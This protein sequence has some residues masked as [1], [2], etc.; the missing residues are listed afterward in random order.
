ME[1]AIGGSAQHETVT[2][3]LASATVG[4][5]HFAVVFKLRSVCGTLPVALLCCQCPCDC[6]TFR[7]F[8][9]S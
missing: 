6:A 7:M 1:M 9:R 3:R 8:E 5:L 4:L 2:R